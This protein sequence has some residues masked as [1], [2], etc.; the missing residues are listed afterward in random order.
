[1]ISI[2]GFLKNLIKKIFGEKVS[3]YLSRIYR[4][5]SLF[6]IRDL[7]LLRYYLVRL[8][9]SKK[10]QNLLDIPIKAESHSYLEVGEKN[11]VSMKGYKNVTNRTKPHILFATEKWCEHNP[12]FGPSN[13]DH[14]FLGS[15]EASG[16]A[17]YDRLNSDE[18]DYKRHRSFDMELLLK[19]IKSKPDLII[20]HWQMAPLKLKTLK[21]IKENLQIP[22]V[23]IWGDLVNHV[24][25]AEV[26]LPFVDFNLVLDTIAAPIREKITQVEKYLWLWTPQDPRIYHNPNIRR[27]ID[28]S[29]LGTMRGHPDRRAGILAL[30]SNGIDVY[31][32]GGQREKRLS[33]DEYA[34]IYK[35][36]KIALNFCYHSNDRVQIKGRVFEATS[37]DAMLMEADNPET[38]KLFKPMVDYVPFIDERDLVEKVR[39]YL[40]H[41][42]ERMEIAA[43]GHKKAKEK[44]TSEIFWKTVFRKVF[45]ADF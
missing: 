3:A 25:E 12:K 14:N 5:I 13:D 42:S 45:G 28:V 11:R 7:I 26:L 16:L 22:V 38:A 23:A 43:R 37:C 8:R 18:Y 10:F 17:T 9:I 39:Y 1:M 30:K 34:L 15:L 35:R 27:D 31:Q 41:D 24:E 36:S 44:Y 20:I 32:T 4:A 6:R 29:F 33:I 2:S 19:S 21:L 40:A